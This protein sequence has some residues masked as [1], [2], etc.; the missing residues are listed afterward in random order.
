[1]PDF[2]AEF[3]LVLVVA[4]HMHAVS[5]VHTHMP[6]YLKPTVKWAAWLSCLSFNA[7]SASCSVRISLVRACIDMHHLST[8]SQKQSIAHM[9]IVTM[10]WLADTAYAAASGQLHNGISMQKQHAEAQFLILQGLILFH[11]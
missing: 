10:R 7:Q 5:T 9:T 6:V 1:M 2:A 11:S 3:V 4:Y 8:A